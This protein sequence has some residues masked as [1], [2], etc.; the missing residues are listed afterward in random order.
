MEPRRI[1]VYLDDL[2]A[3]VDTVKKLQQESE[4]E[5][6]ALKPSILSRAFA[7]EL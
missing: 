7:G 5:L 6:N 4:Q 1:V 3:K 2:H